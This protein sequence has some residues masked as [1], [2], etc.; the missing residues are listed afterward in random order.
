MLSAR[1]DYKG[2][3]RCLEEMCT[4]GKRAGVFSPAAELDTHKLPQHARL[5]CSGRSAVPHR[6]VCELI[7]LVSAISGVV[8]PFSIVVWS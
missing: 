4:E 2:L 7:S 8:G 6:T 1:R 3:F 5:L